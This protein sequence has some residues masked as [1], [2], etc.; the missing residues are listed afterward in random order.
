MSRAAVGE[1]IERVSSAALFGAVLTSAQASHAQ[2]PVPQGAQF[3][4]NGY[5]TG[6]QGYPSVAVDAGGNWVVVW[7]SY[8]S[9]G[10]DVDAQSIQG[11]RY[12]PGGAPAGPQFQVNSDTTGNTYG[13]ANVAAA[14]DGD[15]LV[16]WSRLDPVSLT[17]I[18]ARRFAAD[19]TP[20]GTEFQV[21]TFTTG[22]QC[23]SAVAAGPSGEF[24]VVWQD[25]YIDARLIGPDGQPDGASFHVTTSSLGKE[26]F[27]VIASSSE[28]DFAVAWQA[29]PGYPPPSELRDPIVYAR[30]FVLTS[31]VPA[32][33]AG[34]AAACALGLLAAGAALRRRA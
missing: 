16:T 32:L 11:Q 6:S 7:S 25:S 12:T 9:S 28:G 8:G 24:V 4:V 10:S 23:N 26:L 29:V 33:S 30:R 14:P 20:Q 2:S 34:P 19:G 1:A 3:Q 21:N 13:P 17:D 27:P 15:F 5:T 31:P 22:F 18:R